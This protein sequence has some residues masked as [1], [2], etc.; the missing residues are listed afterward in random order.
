[1]NGMADVIARPAPRLDERNPHGR[2]EGGPHA[3]PGTLPA[4]ELDAVQRRAN[5]GPSA[6][7]AQAYRALLDGGPVQRVK[8]YNHRDRLYIN[9]EQDGQTAPDGYATVSKYFHD[10][11]AAPWTNRAPLIG[12]V[13]TAEFDQL[14]QNSTEVGADRWNTPV[15]VQGPVHTEAMSSCTTVGFRGYA[16]GQLYSALYHNTGTDQTPGDIFNKILRPL[17]TQF[18]RDGL[19]PFD[20]LTNLKFFAIGGNALAETT[21]IS[22]IQAFQWFLPP[23]AQREIMFFGRLQDTL[24]KN[25]IVDE[26]GNI[27]YSLEPG[28]GGEDDHRA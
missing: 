15:A 21:C 24:T 27:L 11:N 17:M 10:Y 5:A 22:I 25:A 9:D 6:S 23:Q 1:M 4:A 16:G 20:Q 28:A 3:A 8:R 14:K 13:E 2:V 19:P 18:G 26:S 7:R 12:R